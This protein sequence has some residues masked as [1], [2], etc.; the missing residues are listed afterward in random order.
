MT[1]R[2]KAT[3]SVLLAALWLLVLTPLHVG[4]AS[5]K[6]EWPERDIELIVPMKPGGG[7]DLV[8]R[9]TAPFIEKYLPKKAN[10]VV[11]NLPGAG[12]KIAFMSLV[13][14]KPDG[15]T[16]G[17]VN[18]LDV[19]ILQVKGLLEGMDLRDLSWLFHI[20]SIQCVLV[21]ATKTG[22]KSPKDM[23]SKTIRFGAPSSTVAFQSAALTRKIGATPQNVS[24]D[25]M[26]EA[27]MAAM[28]GDID[29]VVTMW[30]VAMRQIR[31]SEGKLTPLFVCSAERI[32]QIKEI[33]TAGE[34]GMQL[35]D[36][37]LAMLNYTHVL[38][39]PR[40]L[41]PERRKM[42]EETL[43]RVIVDTEWI[44]QMN[45]AELPPSPIIGKEKMNALI[46]TT[47]RGT[48]EHKDIL[49]TLQ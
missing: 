28:R 23:A 8:A 16:I 10:V 25:G 29:A 34:V 18:P 4:A 7:Y 24:Y 17:L 2:E 41:S 31:G 47:L 35:G 15:L 13:K 38:T 14:A 21:V 32:P 22:F 5:E 39:A 11:K 6:G 27:Y 3:V 30:G 20:D 26:S 12:G 43:A 46:E 36:N 33:P 40:G 37:L 45:K 19:T 48:E 1:N 49:A 44:A 42:W 9:I